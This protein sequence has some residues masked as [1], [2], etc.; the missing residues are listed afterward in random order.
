[1]RRAQGTTISGN[2]AGSPDGTTGLG[3]G[4]YMQD[5]CS[6]GTCTTVSATLLSSTLTANYAHLVGRYSP[7]FSP[8]VATPWLTASPACRP[9]PACSTTAQTRAARCR[10]TAA[11]SPAT[12]WTPLTLAHPR[13]TAW[14]VCFA[15][16]LCAWQPCTCLHPFVTHRCAGGLI[17]LQS[18]FALENNSFANNT[19][20]LGG[21]VFIN[22]DLSAGA[23]LDSL[24]FSGDT[25]AEGGPQ[26]DARPG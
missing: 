14:E 5:S 13:S 15:T 7:P 12:T 2:I 26:Q 25:A 24:S 20:Y 4:I 19:A 11:S 9:A 8:R 3:G 22:A 6:G 16:R 21:G 23:Y 10:S 18:T 1:M 17:L